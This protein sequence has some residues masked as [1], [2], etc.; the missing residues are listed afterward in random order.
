MSNNDEL[1][2]VVSSD[3]VPDFLKF[4]INH[5]DVD[6]RQNN[7]HASIIAPFISSIKEKLRWWTVE[8][9]RLLKM[10]VQRIQV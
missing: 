1:T 2:T 3:S 10:T 9:P 7:C 4:V 5:S 6:S 8:N